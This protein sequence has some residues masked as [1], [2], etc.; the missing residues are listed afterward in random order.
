MNPFAKTA[1]LRW[2]VALLPGPI[3]DAVGT[4]NLPKQH[5]QGGA[6]SN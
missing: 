2:P 4:L 1:R 6:L 5:N 3:I